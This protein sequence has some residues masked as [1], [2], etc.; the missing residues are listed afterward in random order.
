MFETVLEELKG[1]QLSA[2]EPVFP[3]FIFG[4][5]LTLE[6]DCPWRVMHG[7]M[8]I[9][10]NVDYRSKSTH[11]QLLIA[12]KEYLIGQEITAIQVHQSPC[13]M[14]LRLGEETVIQL[15]QASALHESWRLIFGDQFIAGSGNGE[16]ISN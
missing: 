5:A 6:I 14:T 4:D 1:I 3:R 10:G 16:V 15:F 12:L 7:N 13:D 8:I 11:E 9:A 2:I